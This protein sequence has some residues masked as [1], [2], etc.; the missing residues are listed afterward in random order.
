MTV[1]QWLDERARE[2]IGALAAATPPALRD[3]LRGAT[4]LASFRAQVRESLSHDRRRTIV[5]QTLVLLEQNYVHLRTSSTPRR[6]TSMP[7]PAGTHCLQ[8][9]R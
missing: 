6:T 3:R 8:Q 2:V 7:P 9:L 5:E 4:T 1:P